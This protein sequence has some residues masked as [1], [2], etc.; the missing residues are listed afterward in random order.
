MDAY[1]AMAS[2]TVATPDGQ[3]PY[4]RTKYRGE[5][6]QANAQRLKAFWID[7]DVK[8]PGDKKQPGAVYATQAEAFAWL[9]SFMV[10]TTLPRPNLAVNSG[11]G[12]HVY[13][14][15]EDALATQDWQP[16]ADAL[17][18]A[19]LKHNLKGDPG[20]SNDAARILRPPGTSNMK[21][22]VA[23][24]VVDIPKLAAGDYPNALIFAALQPYVGLIAAKVTHATQVNQ[25]ATA[26]ALA[27]G[28]AVVQGVFANQAT[29]NM[30]Q[31]AQASLSP[32]ARPREFARIVVQCAQV[33]LSLDNHG[34][35]ENRPLWLLGNLTLAHFCTDGADFVHLLGDGDARYTKAGTEA[36]VADIADEH[37]TKGMGPPRCA[38][39]DQTRPGVCPTCVHHTKINSPWD[40]GLDDGDLPDNYRRSRRGL[41]VRI[42]TKDDYFWILLL[43]GDVHTPTLDELPLGGY[44]LQFIYQRRLGKVWT[45]RVTGADLGADP[46]PL[47]KFFEKQNLVLMPQTEV[48]WRGFILGWIDRLREQRTEVIH[49]FGWSEDNAGLSVGF[50]VGGTLYTPDGREVATPG[51]DPSL[52]NVYKPKGTLLGWQQAAAFV[53][54]GRPDLQVLVAASFGAPLMTFTGHAGLV[55]SAWSRQSAVG[56]SS[57]IRVGQSIWSAAISLNSVDDTNNFVLKKVAD[58]RSMPCYWDEMKVGSENADKMVSLALSLSQGKG[59]GRLNADTSLKEVGEWDTI[60][61]AASNFPLMDHIV[62]KTDG[63]DAGAVR[64]FEYGIQ[65]PP[66]PDTSAAARLIAQTRTNYGVAGRVYAKWISANHAKVDQIVCTVKDQLNIELGAEQAERFY[67][68]GMAS[69]LAGA[70]IANHLKICPFDLGPLKAFLCQEFLRMRLAR[71]LNVVVSQ[72]GYDLEQVLS[73]FMGD[74]LRHKL[75]TRWFA[76]PGHKK[77]PPD[78]VSWRPQDSNRVDVHVAQDNRILR[79]N[80]SAFVEWCRKKSYPSSDVIQHMGHVWAATC[81]RRSL[82]GGTGWGGGQLHCIDV[83]LVIPELEGYLYVD[84]TQQGATTNQPAS[85]AAALAGNKPKV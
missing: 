20:I 31:A 21:S 84:A 14:V 27:G 30:A 66:T 11:Y 54:K 26:S 60:L 78:F 3:D 8:R 17:K 58:V 13:W 1:H 24:P 53:M 74:V 55:V 47:F 39:Y 44:A 18:A 50:A 40:L 65:R 19:L 81:G 34:K 56:K 32:N 25:A 6:T 57:G 29:P 23:M 43:A 59:K 5:R 64:L 80:R 73:S 36:A 10:A 71:K 63:T 9:K 61:V 42:K 70:R 7:L 62:S 85:P 49:P 51:G 69:I 15:L 77:L 4:G 67:I 41:E 2:Y 38:Y 82:G 33:K 46:G 75:V 68:A 16:Y 22:G 12:I 76:G 35:G 79:I 72:S 45:I 48:H 37:I 28:G 83:P 52:V